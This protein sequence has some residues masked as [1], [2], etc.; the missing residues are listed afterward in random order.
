MTPSVCVCLVC[1][2]FLLLSPVQGASHLYP[3]FI[4]DPW[5]TASGTVGTNR[6]RFLLQSLEDLDQSLRHRGSR[7]IVLRGNPQE[8]L[9]RVLSDWGITH[10]CFESDTEP[11]AKT[12]DAAAKTLCTELGVQ[13]ISSVSHTLYDPADIVA[14]NGGKPPLTMQSFVKVCD[15]LGPPLPPAVDPPMNIPGPA[16]GTPHVEYTTTKGGD[17]CLTWGKV[18]SLSDIGY[19]EPK[20][21]REVSPF[22]GGET[23]ALAR[24][25][26][27]MS[28]HS[29]VCQFEKPMTDP[30]AFIKPSTTVLSPYLK[31]GCLS[32]RLFHARLLD[33]Y[34][35]ANG[36]HAQPPVSLRGQL[37]WREHFTVCGA[38]IPNF[39]RM[40]GNPI[41]KQ[42][43]W[44]TGPVAE[45]RLQ[46]WAQGKT[47]YPWIDAIM[48]QLKT[49][50]WIHHLARHSV[51]CFLT[52]GDLWVSWEEGR[53]VFDKLLLDADWSLNN[54]NWMWLSASA[55]FNTYFRVYSP[56]AF[57]KKYDP[58]GK[59]VR[60]FLPVL[61]DVPDKYIY[62]PWLMPLDVQKRV[63]CIIGKD[64][65]SPIV[66]HAV[67][68]KENIGKMAAA[69]KASKAISAGNDGDKKKKR[70]K[71]AAGKKT[72]EESEEEEEEEEDSGEETTT[73]KRPKK[74]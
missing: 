12:R 35:A 27:M 1:V 63:H 14:K 32:P 71:P 72:K 18:P 66:D 73:T 61:R 11:Y 2:Y 41:C 22:E 31:F 25:A 20:D 16:P 43:P 4:L 26:D 39:D 36:K 21:S 5:F 8:V 24:L 51:A 62:E 64:Y 50:G 69:Y 38:Y 30:S 59:Y 13:V 19:E 40:E 42:V 10:L 60:H 34:R 9:P 70:G 68:H 15:S 48:T 57:G 49:W 23:A 6:M 53:D 65:P 29:W 55:F 3:I 33:I 46:A 47:G 67:V 74:K 37:L 56:V 52:R 58:T 17:S 44:L 28:N 45:H 54:A 7:L